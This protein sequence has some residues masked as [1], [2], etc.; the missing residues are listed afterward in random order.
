MFLNR[1]LDQITKM[2][3]F[4]WKS[5]SVRVFSAQALNNEDASTTHFV[6][7]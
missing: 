4:F 6:V 2:R 1:K 3:F 5:C 7:I